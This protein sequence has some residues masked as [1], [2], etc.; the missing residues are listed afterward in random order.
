MISIG[1]DHGGYEIKE[2]IVA[3]LKENSIPFIDFGTNSSESV[4]YPVFAKKVCDSIIKGES[5][6]GILC[7]GTGIGM[8]IVANKQRGIRAAV[9]SDEFSAKS[10]RAHNNANVLCLGG[11]I[12]DNEKAIKL[13]EIFINTPFEGG[14]HI[15]RVEMFE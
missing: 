2:A 10:T 12:I 8:S 14:R 7:C 5:S 3:Y 13:A 1:C 9:L 15:N 11:R 4:D 6:L